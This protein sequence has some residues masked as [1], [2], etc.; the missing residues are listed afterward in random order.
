[1]SI[2]K[3]KL[4]AKEKY[5]FQL[6]NAM[7]LYFTQKEI[8]STLE[9]LDSLFEAGKEDARTEE[10]TCQN[11]GTP[12]EFVDTLLEE[13]GR[14]RFSKRLKVYIAAGLLLC[15]SLAVL[16]TVEVDMELRPFL[17]CAPVILVPSFVGY[18]CGGFCLYRP[19]WK[20]AGSLGKYILYLILSLLI[21]VV[22]Q[23]FAIQF[24]YDYEPLVPYVPASYGLACF[25]VVVS[26]LVCLM[27]FF[28]LNR[29]GCRS[30]PALILAM[31]AI[32]SSASYMRYLFRY[33][34]EDTHWYPCSLPY[35]LSIMAAIIYS[36]YMK[37]RLGKEK[38][39]EI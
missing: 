22:E 9:D 1:M 7:L 17:L 21:V 35:L 30:F 28:E 26:I 31:G 16:Y 39:K 32:G 24:Y 19:S 14:A 5:L 8:C 18:I 36:L 15:V 11:L 10:E 6:K 38:E 4:S 33:I 27:V 12:K 34:G 37:K 23:A 3:S 29:G 2:I 25:L 13:E 20:R